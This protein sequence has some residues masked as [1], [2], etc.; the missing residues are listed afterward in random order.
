M[1]L[2]EPMPQVFS[3]ASRSSIAVLR[4][5][6][7]VVRAA[8]RLGRREADSRIRAAPGSLPARVRIRADRVPNIRRVRALPVRAP[9]DRVDQARGQDLA[10]GRDLALRVRVDLEQDRAD[11]RLRARLRALRVPRDRR[12]AGVASSIPRPKKAR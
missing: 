3:A 9:V 11:R 1:R 7:A 8:L 4:A 2:R 12:V 10:R 6:L 5:V